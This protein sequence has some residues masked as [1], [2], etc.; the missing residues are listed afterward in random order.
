MLFFIGCQSRNYYNSDEIKIKKVYKN[1]NG[2]I[3][4]FIPVGE[5]VYFA[6]GAN[7]KLSEDSTLIT[8]TFV[9]QFTRGKS[10]K[11]DIKSN[12]IRNDSM[13]RIWIN[14]PYSVK[15]IIVTPPDKIYYPE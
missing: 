9:R 5:S 11:V 13:I 15:K 14:L 10:L 2:V 3:I 6:S 12:Y 7:M 8:L 4:D 1:E